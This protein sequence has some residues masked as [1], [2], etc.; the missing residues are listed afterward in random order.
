M[1]QGLIDY[2]GTP[3]K[4]DLLD[5]FNI[6]KILAIFNSKQ[7]VLVLWPKEL[8]IMHLIL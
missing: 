8:N 7:R 6:L 3:G 5:N 2:P 1:N 4:K